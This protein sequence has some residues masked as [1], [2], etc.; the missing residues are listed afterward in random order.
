LRP[1]AAAQQAADPQTGGAAAASGLRAGAAA[2][3]SS[4]ASS[5]GLTFHLA[6]PICQSTQLQLQNAGGQPTGD[7]RC[8]RCARTFAANSTFVDLTLSSGVPQKAY[9][10]KQWGGTTLFQSPVVSFVYERGWRQGFAWAGFPGADKEFDYAMEYLAPAY[11]ETLVDMSCGSG[12]FSRRFLKSGRFAGVIAADFSESMLG[13]AK[14]YLNEDPTLDPSRYLLLRADVG[15]LPF[16]TGSV[17]AIHA[18][19]AIHCWP[20]PSAAFAEISRVLRPGGLFV[21]STFLNFTAPLGQVVGDE[22]VAPLSQLDPGG[23]NTMR[24]W[25]EPELKEL[26]DTMGLVN[27]RRARS[28]RFILFA[29]S[30]PHQA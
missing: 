17:A 30:K 26:C 20:N 24:W 2:S 16:A 27:F 11:G 14:Q 5:T 1:Q 28:N 7:T 10:Q 18:G 22:L 15:R 6:C 9:K 4:S 8:P 25:S 12:L 29:A 21:A 13:Q 23:P 19:A 3:G